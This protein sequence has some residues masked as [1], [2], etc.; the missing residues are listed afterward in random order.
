MYPVEVVKLLWFI[1]SWMTSGGV[2]LSLSR[3]A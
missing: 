2:L 1:S 3:W